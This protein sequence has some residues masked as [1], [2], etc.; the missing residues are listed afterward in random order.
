MADIM[1]MVRRAQQTSLL[2]NYEL[3][4]RE[5]QAAPYVQLGDTSIPYDLDAPGVIAEIKA[6]LVALG[7]RAAD[8][9][10]TSDP[11]IETRYKD[12]LLDEDVPTWDAATADEFAIAIGRYRG[13]GWQVPGPYAV[14]TPGGPQPTAT[15][16][17]L[18]AGAVNELLGGFPRM[19]RYEQWRSGAF[20]PPSMVSG[21]KANAP[22]RR[23]S[24]FGT[25]FLYSPPD[26]PGDVLEQVA[27][28]DRMLSD[29]WAGAMQAG[30]EQERA[31]YAS[32][33]VLGR[34]VRDA[35]V[36]EAIAQTPV[37]EGTTEVE[38]VD[39]SACVNLGGQWDAATNECKALEPA[40][41]ETE[42]SAPWIIL[43]VGGLLIAGSMLHKPKAAAPSR[44]R[45][46]GSLA[47]R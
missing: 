43:A 35:W 6:A 30:S 42:S 9:F 31:V 5:E 10:Q 18:I 11:A 33:M 28:A 44:S 25:T 20:A 36:R 17:E 4:G 7:Q 39:Q 40:Q 26:A 19:V 47:P 24:N 8:R 29:A 37:R 2:G 45:L 14:M 22:V 23:T 38:H 27:A 41:A 13:W 32:T 1:D 46:A 3:P 15:G 16:L 12:I 21:P 34:S